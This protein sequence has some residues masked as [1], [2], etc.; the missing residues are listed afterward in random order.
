MNA[1][2]PL[3]L[4]ATVCA[5]LGALGGCG[6]AGIRE[7]ADS[8]ANAEQSAAQEQGSV[9][10]T[11]NPLIVT[12]TAGQVRGAE[13]NGVYRFLGVPYA[14][15]KE[16]FV[17]ADPVTPWEGV[18]D[19]LEY[20]AISPQTSFFGN[21]TD[22]QNNNCQNLN[23]WTPATGDS[24]KRLVMVWYHGGG[25]TSGSANDAGTNGANLS[26]NQDVV[27]VTVNHR[28]GVLG[29]LDLSA[30][31]DKYAQSGNVGVLDMTAS[32]QWIHD[33][34]AAFGGDPDNVTV[35]GQSGGGAKV[36]ALMTTP[37][38]KGLFHKAINES[39]ATN[40]LGPVFATTE[41]SVRVAELTLQTLG[42]TGRVPK[43]G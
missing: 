9:E 25:M 10:E 39:G 2:R 6:G 13:E 15:V 3:A 18:R 22:G 7:N 28:L 8:E 40:T 4:L 30:Y 14:E 33:N 20:G 5:L 42:V 17:P 37:A 38:A 27:T 11:S 1:K 34:I 36:L 21:S 31:G 12:T 35:F 32:L 16:R 43:R 24:V 29:Y 26:R 23:I 41:M 19:A